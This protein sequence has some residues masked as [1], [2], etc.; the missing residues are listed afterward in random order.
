[1]AQVTSPRRGG[2]PGCFSGPA[3]GQQHV[4]R[5]LAVK[6]AKRRSGPLTGSQ[7]VLAAVWAMV[8][9]GATD[10]ARRHEERS[11]ERARWREPLK[12]LARS[13]SL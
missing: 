7:D 1:M 8:T 12:T 10:R 11:D 5:R 6:G 3:T 13:A 2:Q 4:R 9:T